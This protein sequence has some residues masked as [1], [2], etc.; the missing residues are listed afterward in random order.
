MKDFLTILLVLISIVL[1]ILLTI[2]LFRFLKKIIDWRV[3]KNTALDA[4]TYNTLKNN[5][6]ARRIMGELN[7]II[8]EIAEYWEQSEYFKLNASYETKKMGNPLDVYATILNSEK[9]KKLKEEAELFKNIKKTLNDCIKKEWDPR[10]RILT[11]N[12]KDYYSDKEL[13]DA[14]TQFV[15]ADIE[16][17]KLTIAGERAQ[18]FKKSLKVAGI[19]II[20]VT[21]LTLGA[22]SAAN[23]SFDK[24][25]FF[26][27]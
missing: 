13:R 16:I 12:S 7:Y 22:V 2:L 5:F 21:G 19:G 6:D 1:P 24:Q 17:Q 25:W 14:Y 4:E 8:D 11:D 3:K 15:N 18:E 9:W 27:H 20:A 26:D 10:I 23:R